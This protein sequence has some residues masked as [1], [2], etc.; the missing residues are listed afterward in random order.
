MTIHC[1]RG[2]IYN[3]LLDFTQETSNKKKALEKFVKA[4]TNELLHL[5]TT[6]TSHIEGSHATLKAYLQMSTGDLH[7]VYTAISLA[8]LAAQDTLKSIIDEPSMALQNP[9]IVRIKG[10][11]SGAPNNQKVNSTK[12][13]PSGFKLVDP[14]AR[15]CAICQQPRHNAC[16]CINKK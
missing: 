8:Q 9:D 4:W 1:D 6:I 5:E 7:H 11:P 15:H 14:K 3:K 16:T 10:H 13:D 12:R 2:G